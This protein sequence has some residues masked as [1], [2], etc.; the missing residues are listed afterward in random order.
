MRAIFRYCFFVVSVIFLLVVTVACAATWKRAYIRMEQDER[1]MK[2]FMS[3]R[4]QMNWFY[5]HLFDDVWRI[6]K[7]APASDSISI[8]LDFR[9]EPAPDPPK[10]DGSSSVGSFSVAA[11][12]SIIMMNAS[13]TSPLDNGCFPHWRSE[14]IA[15]QAVP[16]NFPDF[17][18][19]PAEQ[20][21]Q[22]QIPYWPALLLAAACAALSGKRVFKDLRSRRRV[23][24]GL[25]P[26]CAY[27]LRATPDCCPE[28]GLMALARA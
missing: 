7:V 26:A 16:G 22:V 13:A 1:E 25:C 4:G 14:T 21:R 19:T 27:D 24:A 28:C 2:L 10:H 17:P 11:T 20:I 15:R 18:D 5:F 8:S 3:Y 23:K 12:G 6:W 9:N